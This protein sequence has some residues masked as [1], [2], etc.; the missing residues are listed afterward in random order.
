MYTRQGKKKCAQGK[1]SC[2]NNFVQVSSLVVVVVADSSF[3]LS[4]YLYPERT[5]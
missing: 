4:F 1:Q 5:D 3:L 2:E